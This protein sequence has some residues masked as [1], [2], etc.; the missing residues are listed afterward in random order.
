MALGAGFRPTRVVLTVVMKGCRWGQRM[1]EGGRGP[2]DPRDMRRTARHSL[3]GRWEGLIEG[4]MGWD[5]MREE[6][7][8][9]ERD[10]TLGEERGA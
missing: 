9:R 10:G 5:N 1:A 2:G 6:G 4:R 8:E 7:M 3:V